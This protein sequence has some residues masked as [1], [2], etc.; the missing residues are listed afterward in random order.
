MASAA[1]G[2]TTAASWGAGDFCGGLATKR[3]NVHSVV[4]GAHASGA[5][6]FLALALV[7]REPVPAVANLAACGAAGLFGALGLLA[8]YR[9]LAMGRMG[10]AAPVSGVLSA[11]VPVVAGAFLEGRPGA[12]RLIGFALALIAV[13]LV[14][15]SDDGAFCA[16]DLGLPV[17][18]GLGFGLFIVIVGRAS[19]GSVF[20][21]LVSARAASLCALTLVARLNRQ[22]LLP[23]RG[24]PLVLLAGLF[25]GAGSAFVVLAAHAGRLDVAGVLCSLYPVSTVV[26]AWVFLRE[27]T[28]RWQVAG[29]MLASSAIVMITLP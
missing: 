9:A 2:L 6:L 20:W 10:I 28:S 1:L 23:A 21:P 24:L 14:S 18:A 22:R 7:S 16:A 26:L 13:W 8:L 12:V 11:A 5:V 4:I 15:R 19:G 29:L 17:A 25:D 27:R 3:A